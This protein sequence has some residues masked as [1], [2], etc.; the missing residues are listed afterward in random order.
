MLSYLAQDILGDDDQVK[1][2]SMVDQTVVMA[3]TLMK[4]PG[5]TDST[6]ADGVAKAMRRI[7]DNLRNQKRRAA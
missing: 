6:V 5:A 4:S 2:R 3:Q 7:V 1:I